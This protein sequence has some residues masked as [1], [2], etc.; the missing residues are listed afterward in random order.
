[1]IALACLLM[2]F[3]LTL[4]AFNVYVALKGRMI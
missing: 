1:M 3:W 2:L 4:L